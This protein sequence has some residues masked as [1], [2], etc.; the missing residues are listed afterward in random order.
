MLLVRR[1][2]LVHSTSITVDVDARSAR[3]RVAADG[4]FAIGA[5]ADPVVASIADRAAELGGVLHVVDDG[6]T[7]EVEVPR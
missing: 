3:I 2:P 5:A 6:A 1:A 7:L 4:P